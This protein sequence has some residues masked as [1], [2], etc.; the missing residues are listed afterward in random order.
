MATLGFSIG[1]RSLP[2]Y[3]SWPRRAGGYLIDVLA[4]YAPWL[5][6]PVVD[7]IVPLGGDRRTFAGDVVV[8]LLLV[9]P[10]SILVFNRWVRGGMLGRTWGRAVFGI[11]L[12]D[13]FT[14]EPIGIGRAFVRDVARV[15]DTLVLYLGWVR[16]LW[17]GKR[18]A[19][20]DTATR[21]VVI[22][23]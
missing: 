18:Q 5:L 3:A 14:G 11:R 16:P 21:S 4:V 2:M 1:G 23:G 6:L 12:V 22:R 15:L 19:L 13:E 10:F 17:N 20:A 7:L 8:S 9:A